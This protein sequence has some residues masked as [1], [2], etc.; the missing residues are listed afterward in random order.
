[1]ETTAPRR[2]A[3][4]LSVRRTDFALRPARP[5]D[6]DFLYRVFASTR[7]DE[8]AA[9][10]WDQ[11]QR[12]AVLG[13]QFAAQD[14]YYREHHPGAALLVI[15]KDGRP[16]GRFYV[17]RRPA[18]IRIMEISLLPE[19]RNRGIG[20]APLHDVLAEGAAGGTPVT[21]HV[22]RFNPARRLYARLGSREVADRGVYLLLERS[23]GAA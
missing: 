16:V 4:R 14:A 3:A 20:T 5:T 9:V 7:E 2:H 6:R 13:M 1:M 8:L 23:P 18:E 19:F 11:T 10:G 15:L 21:V 17:H 12:A 22:E